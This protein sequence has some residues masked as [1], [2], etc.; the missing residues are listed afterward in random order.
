MNACINSIR[1]VFFCFG[2]GV[3]G[4]GGDGEFLN[5]FEVPTLL[6][7]REQER[8]TII[9]E[10]LNI[11]DVDTVPYRPVRPEFFVPV[12]EPVL[13]HLQNIPLKIPAYT[14]QYRPYR[15]IPDV[16]AGK[17]KFGRYKN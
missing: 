3:G 9:F 16:S 6:E 8:G 15:S 13:K 1:Q 12:N 4:C 5:Y 11:K 14:R 17:E 10:C 7:G 2:V